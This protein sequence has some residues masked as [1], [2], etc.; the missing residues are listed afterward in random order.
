MTFVDA[1]TEKSAR[2][3]VS[4]TAGRGRV[5]NT[6]YFFDSIKDADSLLF[7]L[8]FQGKSAA[9]GVSIAA[10]VAYGFSNIYVTAPSPENLNTLFEFIFTGLEQQG[11]KEN[12]HYDII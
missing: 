2:S 1:I 5:S 4:L 11:Y 9:I 8:I 7:L 6:E 10:A 12:M 3:T